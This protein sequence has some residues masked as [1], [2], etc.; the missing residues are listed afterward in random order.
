MVGAW[1]SAGTILIVDDDAGVRELASETLQ[2]AGL[3][4]LTASDGREAVTT[5][6]ENADSIR[7]VLLDRTMPASGGEEAFVRIREIEP[8]VPI[9]LVS[10]YA[11]ASLPG[12]LMEPGLSSFLQKPF[13]PTALLTKVRELL[14]R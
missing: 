4:V 10:G 7:L 12:L 11:R 2:R 13:L 5:F 6:T 9:L 1:R 8:R 3:D 14:D